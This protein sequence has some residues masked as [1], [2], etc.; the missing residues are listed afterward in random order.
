VQPLR[1]AISPDSDDAFMAWAIAAGR[2]DTEGLRF[3]LSTGDVQELNRHA[4]SDEPPFDISA[5]S[6][7]ALPLLA[8]RW[9]VLTTAAS[10]GIGT[11]PKVVVPA[12]VQQTPEDPLAPLAGRRIA[13]PGENTSARLCFGLAMQGRS[14][15][16][17]YV[18]F[19]G[20]VPTVLAG[21][22]A[23]GVI[24]HEEGLRVAEHDLRL[25]LDLGAWW[26][27]ASGGLP[28]PLGAT[29]V[30]RDLPAELK[31]RIQGVLRA[32]IEV[33][34]QN[35]AEALA[36]ARPASK[37]LAP[38]LLDRYIDDY[39]NRLSVDF[40]DEGRRALMEFLRRAEAAGLIDA[41]AERVEI[42]SEHRSAGAG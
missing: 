8:D 4:A 3:E 39:V 9:S 34:L 42:V 6:F 36:Y 37:G 5:I 31:G 18:P 35:R 33:G 26:S 27:E 25:V 13:I 17:L 28:L 11:G 16:P 7:G 14:F 22:A 15:E 40:G 10:F 21:D 12:N 29:A 23:G 38:G 19:D 20:I 2:V 30:R 1:L 24:I 41:T 32:A